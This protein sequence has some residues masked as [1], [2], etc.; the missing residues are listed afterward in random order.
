MEK[1]FNDNK[2][3]YDV[4]LRNAKDTIHEE[5]LKVKNLEG[6]VATL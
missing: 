1:E 5:Q 3:K 2:T 6:L 4:E